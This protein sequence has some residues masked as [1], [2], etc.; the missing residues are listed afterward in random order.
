M[1]KLS[2]FCSE[3]FHR[4][5][6]RRCCSNVVNFSDG[7]SAKLCV[8]HHTHKIR[9]RLKLSLLR[10]SHAARPQHLAHIVPDFIQISELSAEL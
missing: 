9:L 8:I 7:K 2:K 10:V 1:V 3:S 5:T 4:L 6:D